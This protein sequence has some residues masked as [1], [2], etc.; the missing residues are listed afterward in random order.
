MK[1]YWLVTNDNSVKNPFVSDEGDLD[2]FE[3]WMLGECRSFDSWSGRAWIR[4]ADP[5][6]DGNPDDSLQN[7][8][9]LLIFSQRLQVALTEAAI[10]GI[11]YLPI[12]VL[13]PSGTR[14]EGFSIANILGCVNALDLERS[15]SSRYPDDYFL[16]ERRGQMNSLR[17][18]T[19]RGDCLQGHDIVR[20]NVYKEKVYV[21]ARFKEVV[22]EGR[23]TGLSFHEVNLS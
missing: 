18:V 21:S 19:L 12:S 13:R 9:A 2:G 20:L 7:H 6:N 23:F 8:F 1:W 5:A 10:S 17:R 3:E 4:A 15:T 22:E 11:Q 14:I 16:S